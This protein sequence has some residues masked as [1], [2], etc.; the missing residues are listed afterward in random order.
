[1]RMASIHHHFPNKEALR[2]ALMDSYPERITHVLDRRL[3]PTEYGEFFVCCLGD[4]LT[5]LCGAQSDAAA[6]LP[7]SRTNFP[8]GSHRLTCVDEVEAGGP[9]VADLPAEEVSVTGLGGNC[10]AGMT[11]VV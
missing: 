10:R 9:L 4:E 6:S 7:A 11:G 2:K 8:C 1:M 5:P 3:N